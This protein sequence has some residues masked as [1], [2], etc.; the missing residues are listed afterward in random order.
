MRAD[1]AG[2][3]VQAPAPSEFRFSCRSPRRRPPSDGCSSTTA[4]RRPSWAA[5]VAA[6]MPA[7]PPPTTTRS[8]S[9]GV[10]PRRALHDHAVADHEEACSTVGYSI[11]D[12]TAFITMADAAEQTAR[13]PST[14]V[15]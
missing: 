5:A 13:F 6:L 3:F 15:A 12:D 8:V 9:I 4:T 10:Y 1:R 14:G 11:H 2:P 7:G